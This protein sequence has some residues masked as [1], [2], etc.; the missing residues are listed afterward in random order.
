MKKIFSLFLVITFIN[1]DIMDLYLY[2]KE[3]FYKNPNKF[4]KLNSVGFGYQRQTADGYIKDGDHI[5]YF[6]NPAAEHDNDDEN[7]TGNLGL[8]DASNPFIWIKFTH[9]LKNKYIPYLKFQYT[10]YDAKGHSDQVVGHINVAGL[11]IDTQI[12]DAKTHQ[13]IDS[14]DGTLF[15]HYK[16]LYTE[17]VVGVGLDYWLGKTYINGKDDDNNS[18][19]IEVDWS[20]LLPYIYGHLEGGG[21][22]NG[23]E[24]SLDFK[25]ADSGNAHHY[26]FM[27]EVR[28][29]LDNMDV[30]GG[31]QNP[32]KSYIAVG[33]RYKEA[34]QKDGNK[35][36]LIRYDGA[37]IEGVLKF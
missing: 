19:S 23:F 31:M 6:N 8:Q 22:D 33:Y 12:H 2:L 35:S 13:T 37:Y 18:V 27:G 7:K 29:N 24:G 14:F 25:W 1:A 17:M 20:A 11:R 28:Y 4:F 9:N 30:V 26:D 3:T 5:N 34:Y 32:F 21:L 16:P 10:A 36:V 15:W